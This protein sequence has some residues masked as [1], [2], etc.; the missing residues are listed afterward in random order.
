MRKP[1]SNTRLPDPA[2]AH[3]RMQAAARAQG[4]ASWRPPTDGYTLL[5]QFDTMLRWKQGGSPSTR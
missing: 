2:S 1:G 5:L 3:V 4:R